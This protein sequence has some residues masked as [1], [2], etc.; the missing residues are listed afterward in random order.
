MI[1][2]SEK[3]KKQ[4]KTWLEMAQ[5]DLDFARDILHRGQRPFYAAHFCHQAIEKILKAIIQERTGETP[6]R[7][8]N[9]SLLRE[10]AGITLPEEKEQALLSLAPHYLSTRYPEDIN[11]L[12]RH[13]TP[14]VVRDLFQ[15]TEEL[16]QWFK[17][18]LST[19]SAS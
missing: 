3:M 14:D 17:D 4:T 6:P 15:R 19:S 5:N 10:R 16:F 9:F 2:G 1:E 18:I 13:Y 11:E 8:H 12:Y 7:I